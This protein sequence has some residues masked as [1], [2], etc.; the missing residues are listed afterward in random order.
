MKR[1]SLFLFSLSA[2]FLAFFLFGVTDF[3]QNVLRGQIP[4]NVTHQK[5]DD[6]YMGAGLAPWDYGLAP[7]FVL[8][9]AGAVIAI[10]KRASR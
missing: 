2:L 9:I 8:A 4:D 3:G 5:L 7:S 10:K 1:V 6:I